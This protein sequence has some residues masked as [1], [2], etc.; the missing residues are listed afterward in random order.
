MRDFYTQLALA[1]DA[2]DAAIRAALPHLPAD[3]RADAQM[4]LLDP[5]RRAIY[6]RNYRLLT[7]IGE[8]RMHLGLNHTRFWSRQEYRDFRREI[9]PAPTATP[10]PGRRVDPMLIA[11]AFRAVGRHGRRHATRKSSWVFVAV[12]VLIVVAFAVAW[13]FIR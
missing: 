2:D 6:D 1:P 5:R 10:P 4:I 11:S 7:T 13:Q 12:L 8:L 3:V 9:A